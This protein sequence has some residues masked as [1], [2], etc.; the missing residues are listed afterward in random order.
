MAP[1]ALLPKITLSMLAEQQHHKMVISILPI[2][3]KQ[4]QFDMRPCS[5]FPRPRLLPRTLNPCI[6]RAAYRLQ[7]PGCQFLRFKVLSHRAKHTLSVAGRIRYVITCDT[8]I[9][10]ELLCVLISFIRWLLQPTQ[11]TTCKSSSTDGRTRRS[12]LHI[13]IFWVRLTRALTRGWTKHVSTISAS[14]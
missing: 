1:Q 9:Q 6:L 10:L 8:T 14:V 11:P 12:S 3:C 5:L 2:P 4:A 7:Q 13:L